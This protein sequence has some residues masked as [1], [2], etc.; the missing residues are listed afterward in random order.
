M[1]TSQD[2]DMDV[3]IRML[4]DTYRAFLDAAYSG[5]DVNV[6]LQRLLNS[7]QLVALEIGLEL[8]H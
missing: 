8:T 2:V 3:Y 1:T 6:P 5:K 7:V 4:D